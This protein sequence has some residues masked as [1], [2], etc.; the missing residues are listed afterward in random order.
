MKRRYEAAE[1]LLE[2]S[3]TISSSLDLDKVVDLVLKESIKA[4]GADH[5]S[6][7]LM[8]EEFG[9]LVL[10]KVRGFSKDEIGNIKLLASWEMIND[11]LMKR[12]KPIC[13][14]DIYVNRIFRAKRL[15][16]SHERLPIKSFIA[17]P[18]TKEDKTVGVLMVSKKDRPGH[19]FTAEDEKLLSALSSNVA[20]ALLNA[21][22]HRNLKNLFISTVKSLVRAVEAKDPYTSGHSERVMRY[23]VAIGRELK[24]DNEFMENLGL[25]SILHD[26]GK[27]GIREGILSKPGILNEEERSEIRKH[28]AIGVRIVETIKD[29][30]SI[31]T[32]ILDHH[33]RFDGSGYPNGLKGKKISLDGRI[34][35]VADTFDALTTD[36]PYQNGRSP[37]EAVFEILRAH[38][39][40]DPK[41]VKAFL[42]SFSKYPGIWK[43][44]NA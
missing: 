3:R 8:D 31:T 21:K 27:I 4:L 11:Q 2:V 33:E 28:P 24:E 40:Y 19:L 36:R 20:V 35:A 16:F 43:A 9:K 18:L 7:F 39:Q 14:N 12:R 13:I 41:V 42:K 44:E 29:S 23:S 6:L 15:P 1:I 37:K 38:S 5:A 10:E 22:L 26:V 30:K 25:S 32:G 34:I 17:V